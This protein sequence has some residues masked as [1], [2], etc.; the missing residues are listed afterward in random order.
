MR[1]IDRHPE[2]GAGPHGIDSH[3]A[4]NLWQM[5][6]EEGPRVEAGDVLVILESMKLEPPHRPGRR[7]GPR[8]TRAAGFG[9][10][11]RATGGSAGASLSAAN[12][13]V[14]R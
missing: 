5:Q 6:V 11:H 10:A 4:D 3:I 14:R 8:G 9:G 2:R 1:L 13:A 12:G 7:P